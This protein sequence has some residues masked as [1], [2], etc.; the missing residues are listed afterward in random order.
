MKLRFRPVVAG[1]AAAG[2]VGV[3]AAGAISAQAATKAP[4]PV[5]HTYWQQDDGVGAVVTTTMPDNHTVVVNGNTFAASSP[6]PNSFAAYLQAGSGQWIFGPDGNSFVPPG[7]GKPAV[8]ST[9]G[10]TKVWAG[11]VD[12]YPVT[13]Y[14]GKSAYSAAS[15]LQSWLSS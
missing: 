15:T 9:S 10:L 12:G 5:S 11:K 3:I 2:V 1:I 7:Y 8:P 4:A 6:G 14:T 13:L